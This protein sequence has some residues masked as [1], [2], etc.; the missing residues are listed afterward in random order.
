[1]TADELV[2]IKAAA[3]DA[4][5]IWYDRM[6]EMS[7]PQLVETLLF[8]M[9]AS[10]LRLSIGNITEDMKKEKEYDTGPQDPI[11]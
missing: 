6:H 4:L 7:T 9:P 8:Y 10:V 2:A 11:E 3:P 1:M 5:S